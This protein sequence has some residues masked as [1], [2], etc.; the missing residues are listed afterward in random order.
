M[1]LQARKRVQV[2]PD[3][4]KE[5]RN[6][7]SGKTV[8]PRAAN[9]CLVTTLA[10]AVNPFQ[11]LPIALPQYLSL[12]CAGRPFTAAIYVKPGLRLS[13]ESPLQQ[14]TDA[15]S[16]CIGQRGSKRIDLRDVSRTYFP[17][18]SDYL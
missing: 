9:C 16:R 10:Y 18:L 13:P 6:V 3:L 12:E 5:T 2:L 4:G 1:M 11:K 17:A 7:S 8:S 15:A 14:V